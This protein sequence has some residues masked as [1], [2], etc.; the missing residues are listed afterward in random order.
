MRRTFDRTSRSRWTARFG[1]L[2]AWLAVSA[3]GAPVHA[4]GQDDAV[5]RL[6]ELDIALASVGHR[7]AIG[8]ADLCASRQALAGWVVQ[9][10]DQY[11]ARDRDAIARR[12][13]FATPLVI[14]GVVPGSAA[15][16]AGLRA[17]DSLVSVGGK[18][19]EAAFPDASVAA[20]T[21]RLAAFERQVASLDP[22]QLI[23]V[24]V[25]REG[26]VVRTSITASSG[27]ASRFEMRTDSGGT[28]RADGSMVQIGI[29]HVAGRTAGPLEVVVAHELAHNILV[30]R[31]RL[32]AQGVAWGMASGLGRNVRYFRQTEVEADILSVHLL[33]GA[34]Y[35]PESAARFWSAYRA[36]PGGLFASRS[37]PHWRDRVATVAAEAQRIADDPVAA[38]LYARQFVARAGS[39]LDG[40]WQSLLVREER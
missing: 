38:R 4:S 21:A 31:A 5:A 6:I 26:G 27:C 14:T 15:D 18:P 32:E 9:A 36:G 24:E 8:N 11:G 40:D 33:A 2:M 34:G 39:P 10:I 30:H 1:A 12:L 7:L 19:L 13:R 16:R 3:V 17:G 29:D 20:T 35:D 22:A 25:I 37:H 23:A 28:A